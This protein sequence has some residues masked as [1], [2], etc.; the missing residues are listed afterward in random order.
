MERDVLMSGTVV[1]TTALV[2]VWVNVLLQ[3]NGMQAIPVLSDEEIALGIT[4][5]VNV[6][7][8]FKNNYITAKGK[9][10]ERVL[11]RHDLK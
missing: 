11:E 4:F 1:R 6:W 7:T 2:L 5:I 8:W 10:Q 3:Q 9:A